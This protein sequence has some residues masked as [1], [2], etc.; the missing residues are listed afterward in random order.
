M[1][2]IKIAYTLLVA[3]GVAFSACSDDDNS[4]FPPKPEQDQE[5][6]PKVVSTQPAD[7]ENAAD[8]AQAIT[9]VYNKE[10]H[11][12]PVTTISVNGEY[13]D[14]GIVVEGNTLTIPYQT[15]PNKRYTVTISSPSVRDE[16]Y[17]FSP[18]YTFSFMTKGINVLDPSMFQL[19]KAPVNPNAN[20]QAKALYKV[21]LDNFGY[22][23]ISGAVAEGCHDTRMANVMKGMSGKLPVINCFDFMEHYQCAPVNPNGWS[24][25]NYQDV[26]VDTKWASNGGIV[27]YQ[28][29][30]EVP[31]SEADVENFNNYA[32]YCS[33]SGKT[34]D[35]SPERALTEGTWENKVITRDLDA[36]AS[37]LLGLQEAGIPV[38]WRPLHE[39]S[40]IGLASASRPWFW[41]GTDGAEVYKKLWIHMFD[42]FKAKGVNNLVWVWTSCGNDADWYPG[43][44]YVDVIGV[45]Y[46]E[47]N[48][49]NYHLSLVENMG[50]LL[51]FSN[52]KMLALSECGALP[53]V[54]AMVNGGDMWS[55]AVPWNGQY[56][57]DPSINSPEFFREFLNSDFVLTQDEMTPIK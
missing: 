14:Q 53:S 1:K 35:F 19:D 3:A 46:Y 6:A 41:W 7:S 31:I 37:Y 45:D 43:D 11:I 27:S 22:R 57:T 52:R 34:T 56:T 18:T 16:E 20:T 25:A 9:V 48:P 50:K 13:I 10:I 12:T 24:K 17:N 33:G 54:D 39:A 30:W 26:S 55:F 32:F 8:M 44:E 2:T 21:L 5:A 38:L 40:G 49:E 29:H 47:N 42:T 28:W 15:M 36:I 51:T 4:G 23:V